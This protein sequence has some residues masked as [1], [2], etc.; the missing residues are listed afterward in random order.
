MQL[1]SLILG[2]CGFDKVAI[3]IDRSRNLNLHSKV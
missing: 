1:D 3:E 2:N